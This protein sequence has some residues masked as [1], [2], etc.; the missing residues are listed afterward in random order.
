MTLDPRRSFHCAL[1]LFA[2]SLLPACLGPAGPDDAVVALLEKDPSVDPQDTSLTGEWRD[3]EGARVLVLQAGGLVAVMPL[4]GAPAQGMQFGEGRLATARLE[5]VPHEQGRSTAT[6][7]QGLSTGAVRQ[8]S[9]APESGVLAFDSGARWQ[10]ASG[11]PGAGELAGLWRDEDG[12]LLAIAHEERRVLVCALAAPSEAAFS[13]AHA[14]IDDQGRLW[15][16]FAKEGRPVR[17]ELARAQPGGE[18][19]DWDGGERW[20]REGAIV[21]AAPGPPE[22]HSPPDGGLLPNAEDGLLRWDFDWSDVPGA[23]EY[24]LEVAN[25]NLRRSFIELAEIEGSSHVH[26]LHGGFLSR[27]E[28]WSWRVSAKVGGDWA[29]WSDRQPFRVSEP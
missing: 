10:R 27:T 19:I 20:W 11:A 9:L 24:R 21:G 23:T 28:G 29:A 22:L 7:I 8:A 16:V 13:V 5:L 14:R 17:R 12:Q 15:T 4:E 3:A 18:T 25:E 6:S 1:A 2:T 26:E